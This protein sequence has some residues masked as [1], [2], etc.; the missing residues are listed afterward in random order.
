VPD[1]L[2]IFYNGVL[3]S[4]LL[5]WLLSER[6]KRFGRLLAF[7]KTHPTSLVLVLWTMFLSFAVAYCLCFDQLADT[8]DIPN[9]VDSAV[10]SQSGGVNPYS[11]DVVPRFEDRYTSH[12]SWSFGPYN[13]LALDLIV[14]Y[15]IHSV[16]GGLGMPFWFVT[17][18][19]MFSAAAFI[20]LQD[21][22]QVKWRFYAPI[23]GIAMLFYSFDNASLTFLL[24]VASMYLY[25]RLRSNNGI[26]ATIVL[27]LAVM[28]KIYAIIPFV[29][30]VLYELQLRAHLRDWRVFAKVSASVGVSGVIATGLM[31]PFGI[32]NVIKSAVLFHLSAE[33]RVGTSSGGT[34]LSEL[35]LSDHLSTIISV[36]LVLVSVIAA[37]RL[38][39][40][41]NRML[42]VS[43]VLLVVVS[44][45]SQ[46]LLVVPGLFLVL[47]MR[48]A[49]LARRA[50]RG[51]APAPRFSLGEIFKIRT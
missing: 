16:A 35:P 36:A 13:Y 29:V 2:D 38:K 5:L 25:S 30:F 32:D 34:F 9:A 48:E 50:Q 51:E 46:A 28:T 1:L 24:I 44:K 23:A 22:V 39:S 19:L 47:R 45:S 40:L 31:L 18:N 41:N 20:I 15:G 21:M 4:I 33:A 6:P 26:V 43:L 7:A 42:L 10:L 27:G 12:P 37:L 3:L 17:A 8:H 14:Y 49:Y 11:H